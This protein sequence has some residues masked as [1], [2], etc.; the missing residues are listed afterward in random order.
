MFYNSYTPSFNYNILYLWMI[1]G[2]VRLNQGRIIFSSVCIYRITKNFREFRGFYNRVSRIFFR[3]MPLRDVSLKF[4]VI[5]YT[6]G[7]CTCGG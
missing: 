2:G 4:L 7:C 5:R 6:Q 3:E 1:I